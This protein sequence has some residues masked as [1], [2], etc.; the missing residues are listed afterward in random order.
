[1]PVPKT[2][3][4]PLGYAPTHAQPSIAACLGDARVNGSTN[5]LHP[6]MR[7]ER[8]AALNIDEALAQL[9]SQLAGAA[10][11]DGEAIV[12]A[13]H[14]PDG[15]HHG[16][17]AAGECFNELTALNVSAPLVDGVAF[18]TDIESLFAGQGKQAV[19]GYAGQDRAIER[20]GKE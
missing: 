20:R 8:I 15:R 6:A 2:S 14:A 7:V 12:A 18:L 17:R 1:M 19:T 3:A 5:A 4:L 13:G 9:L 11:A 10:T 16:C